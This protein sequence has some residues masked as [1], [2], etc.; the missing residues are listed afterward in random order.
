MSATPIS[1]ADR[2]S[3]PEVLKVIFLPACADKANPTR[4]EI[5]AGTDLSNEVAD[6]SGWTVQSNQ[7]DAPDLGHKFTAQI[8]G[9]TTAPDS[10][11]V[12]YADIT[13]ADVRTVLPRGTEG[14]ILMADGGDV[15][16]SKADNFPIKVSSV[17]KERSVGDEPK[18][19]TIQFSITSEP[20]ED[21]SIPA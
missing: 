1:P 16:A 8:S 2:Y 3:D 6:L 21:V 11:I 9:R 4:A 5:D 19:L 15:A 14:F 7:I 20:A 13:G 18:R 12:F 10:S 17:G